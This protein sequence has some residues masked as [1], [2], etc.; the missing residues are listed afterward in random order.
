MKY[1]CAVIF[2]AAAFL[3][4]T[5]AAA[6]FQERVFYIKGAAFRRS[7]QAPAFWLGLAGCCALGTGA[8]VLAG[9]L[10]LLPG[11]LT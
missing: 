8:L 10:V 5:Y 2:A 1:L 7:T 6:C 3:L 11:D 4:L 9:W